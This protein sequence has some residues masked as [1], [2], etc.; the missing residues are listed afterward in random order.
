MTLLWIHNLGGCPFR[1]GAADIRQGVLDVATPDEAGEL[2]RVIFFLWHTGAGS[3]ECLGIEQGRLRAELWSF[4]H[5]LTWL[6]P[7]LIP[8]K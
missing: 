7:G 8:E 2:T 1:E 5:A 4:A 3:K 6:P